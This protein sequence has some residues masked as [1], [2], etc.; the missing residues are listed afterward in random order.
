MGR[1]HFKVRAY[2]GFDLPTYLVPQI[3][4]FSLLIM[5]SIGKINVSLA[6]TSVTVSIIEGGLLIS[7]LYTCACMI[8]M[9]GVMFVHPTYNKDL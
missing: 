4:H 2:V 7:V 5:L 8:F 6:L 1:R 3:L 9:F